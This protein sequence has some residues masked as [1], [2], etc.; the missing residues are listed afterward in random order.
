MT[1]EEIAAYGRALHSVLV[2]TIQERPLTEEDACI[3]AAAA[4]SQLLSE[5]HGP[6]GAVEFLREMADVLEA[7]CLNAA[8]SGGALQ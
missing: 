8:F 2:K 3:V 7:G 5:T 1:I 6:L 4:L